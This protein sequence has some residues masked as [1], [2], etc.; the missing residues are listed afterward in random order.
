MTNLGSTGAETK[1]QLKKN[2]F[3]PLVHSSSDHY[4]VDLTYELMQ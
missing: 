3:H 1:C 2:T 4:I